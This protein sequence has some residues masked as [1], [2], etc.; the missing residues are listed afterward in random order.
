MS[1]PIGKS[2]YQAPDDNQNRAWWQ[3]H[4]MTYDW[5]ATLSVE[6]GSRAW[7]D[8]IDRRFFES[9]YYAQAAGAP[10]FAKFMPEEDVRGKR[11][12]EIGCGMGTHAELLTRRGA[13]LTA[14]DQTPFAVE[15]TTRR[16]AMKDLPHDVRQIDAE[17]M[18]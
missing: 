2:T 5:E 14:V 3:D 1:N 7:Y 13:L 11:V 10:P 12:L 4:P 15:A 18:P 6:R 8:E 17:V 16:L 9:A